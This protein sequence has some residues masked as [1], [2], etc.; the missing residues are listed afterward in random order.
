M[1]STLTPPREDASHRARWRSWLVVTAAVL[2]VAG[3]A[4][5]LLVRAAIPDQLFPGPRDA[6]SH[7]TAPGKLT[8]FHVAVTDA[9]H[10]HGELVVSLT[11]VSADVRADSAQSEITYTLCTTIPADRFSSSTDPLSD[12]CTDLQPVIDGIPVRFEPATQMLVATVTAS[13]PGVT[14][15]DK[16]ALTYRYEYRWYRFLPQTDDTGMR[17]RFTVP[18]PPTPPAS[19]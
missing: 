16:F 19:R 11:E 14:L 7:R 6:T 12:T 18:D 2:L 15:I 1:T 8:P 9:D 13:R 17:T 4:V 5:A 3:I 10:Q